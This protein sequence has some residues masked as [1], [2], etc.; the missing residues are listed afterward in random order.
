MTHKK[1]DRALHLRSYLWIYEDF[2]A[3]HRHVADLP[4]YYLQNSALPQEEEYGKL[5]FVM[6]CPAEYSG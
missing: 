3:V 6:G 5:D 1:E 2:Q 4:F